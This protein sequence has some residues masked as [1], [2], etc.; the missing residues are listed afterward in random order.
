[1]AQKNDGADKSE[2]PTPKRLR[3]ARKKGDV[4]KSR[5]LGAGLLTLAWLV[6]FL[7]ASGYVGGE[8]ARLATDIIA[9]A[10]TVPFDQAASAAGWDAVSTLVRI[11]FVTLVPVALIATFAEFLQVG[12]ILTTEKLKFGLEKMNPIEGLKRMFGKDGLFEL[13]KTLVKVALICLIAWIVLR[14]A[15]SSSTQLIALAGS[16]PIDSSGPA[17][18]MASLSQTWSLTLQMFAMVVCV[19]LFVAVA[20]RLYAKASFIKKMKMSR[21]DIKQ[22]HREDE[23]DPQVKSM[24]REMHQEWANQN[25]IGATRGS[26]ALLVNPT[27]ISIA[28]DYDLESCPVPVIAAKGAGPL[29]AAMRAEAESAGVPIIRNV[30][31]ARSLWARGEIGE[32][33]PEDMFDAIAA[34]ILWA[35]KARSGEAPMWQDMDGAVRR[36]A[37]AAAE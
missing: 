4:A 23:G 8:L 20:D 5:D 34:V 36:P 26:A 24:R 11:S 2:L 31:T 16:S 37:L 35:S 13:A 12:P 19:F 6:L 9:G 30:R 25:A 33:V 21:R 10:T 7:A 3:D 29:A 18:A 27:H 1:M 17:A 15:L 28:L 14:N 22:E 32:I